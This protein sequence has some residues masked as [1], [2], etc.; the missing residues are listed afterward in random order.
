MRNFH[1]C[2]EVCANETSVKV[3]KKE[4]NATQTTYFDVK[5]KFINATEQTM[6]V[7][8]IQCYTKDSFTTYMLTHY[9]IKMLVSIEL[10]FTAV[11]K[12]LTKIYLHNI[13]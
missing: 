11:R 8:V 6:G 7:L 5:K 1:I 12:Y 2:A 3:F 4:I 13:I 9:M 10:M